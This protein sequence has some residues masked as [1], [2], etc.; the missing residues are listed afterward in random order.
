MIPKLQKLG[1]SPYESKSYVALLKHGSLGGK[2]VAKSSGGP[3]TSVYRNLESLREKGFVQLL[4]Q[5]PLVYR[6]VE[7]EIAL[8][9][10]VNYR[11]VLL[12]EA[13][14][15]AIRELNQIKETGGIGKREEV[16]EVYAGREQSYA[17]GKRLI[18]EAKT[19]VLMIGRG[20]GQSILNLIH[21]LKAAVERKV[22]AKFIITTYDENKELVQLLKDEGVKVKYFPLHNFSMLVKDGEESQLVVKGEKEDKRVKE[23]RT[24]LRI[25]SRDLAKAHQHYFHSIWRKATSV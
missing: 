11:K 20:T 10:F 1:L 21:D 17:L 8:T 12:E 16:L 5:E 9:H 24:V 6:A 14:N 22:E 15:E 18:L 19:E 2:E 25:K 13:E 3:P 4:Q 23:Q 7:P